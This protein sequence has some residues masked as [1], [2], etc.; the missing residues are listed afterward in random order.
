MLDNKKVFK[1]NK[2]MVS[3]VI[4]GETILLPIV[5]TSKEM[6]AIYS[7]NKSAACVWEL[8]DGKKSVADIKESL[9]EKYDAAPS[10]V[11][12]KVA[13]LINELKNIEAVV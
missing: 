13:T 5:R 7:L 10:E 9:T 4:A 6:N 8:I 12:K 1:R 3:R 2:N 11:E